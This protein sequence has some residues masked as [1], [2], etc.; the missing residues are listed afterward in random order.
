[1]S[2]NVFALP[3]P[4]IFLVHLYILQYPHANKPEYDHAMFDPRV[5]GLRDRTKTMEDVCYFLVA[6]IEGTKELARRA[7]PTYPCLQPADTIA[8]RT[9]LAKLLEN[10][11]HKSIFPNESGKQ[12]RPGA[13]AKSTPSAGGAAWWWK[14]VVVRKS[15]LEECGG[16]RFER[17]LLAL[18]THALFNGSATHVELDETHALLRAQPRIYTAQSAAFQSRQNAWARAA[19]QLIQQQSDLKTLR[20]RRPYIFLLDQWVLIPAQANVLSFRTKKYAG[21]LTEKLRALADAKLQD[22][23]AVQW[24]HFALEF[25]AELSGLDSLSSSSSPQSA[26]EGTLSAEVRVRLAT[27]PSDF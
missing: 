13:T 12:S 9:S 16:E 25:L 15:L 26:P 2:P 18:S 22:L 23:L 27:P 3:V 6:R 20:V 10:L 4:L 21:L 5:R 11:R 24:D 1:M 8:F 19:S 14:D 17:L 7:L